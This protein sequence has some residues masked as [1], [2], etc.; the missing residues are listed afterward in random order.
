[1]KIVFLRERIGVTFLPITAVTSEAQT[2]VTD[3]R[4]SGETRSG[5]SAKK[6][7][8]CASGCG[9]IQGERASARSLDRPPV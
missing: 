1:M 6:L 7:L 9:S 5:F 3:R 2:R 8:T 4:D